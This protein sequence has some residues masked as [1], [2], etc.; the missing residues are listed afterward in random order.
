MSEKILS[1]FIDEAG[2]FGEYSHHSPYYIIAVVLHEQSNSIHNQVAGLEKYLSDLGYPN[3]AIHSGPLIRREADYKE[4][5]I[6]EFYYRSFDKI[7]I[8]YDNGQKPLKRIINNVFSSVFSNVEVRRVTPVDYKLFQV[9]DLICTLEHITSKIE[10]GLF[11]KTEKEFFT[12]SHDFKRDYWK[13]INKQR[14]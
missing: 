8:Y 7:I 11:S 12:K 3:H 14:F 5:F 10:L 13:K 2:D 1:C 9:A 4:L 6:N